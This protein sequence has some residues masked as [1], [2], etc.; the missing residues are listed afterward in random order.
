MTKNKSR[1][2]PEF[3]RELFLSVSVIRMKIAIKKIRIAIAFF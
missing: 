3:F 1:Q 2:L